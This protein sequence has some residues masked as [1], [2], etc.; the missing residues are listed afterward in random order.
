MG[1]AIDHN[2]LDALLKS[3]GSSWNAG[4]AHGLLCSRLSLAG[5]EGA[6]RWIVQVL[7]DTDADAAERGACEE[8]LDALCAATWQQLVERQSEFNLL[9]P[10]DE[11]PPSVRTEV[12]AQWCE[13]FLHGLVAEKHSEELKKRL[14]EEPL[15][16][17][18]KDMLEITR[19]TVGDDAEDQNIDNDIAELVEY[20]R[21]AV[22]LTYEE[23]AEFRKVE[24][25]GQPESSESLH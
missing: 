3:C 16:D 9:L 17:I 24:D 19:A 5:A 21:V 20:L 25:S 1:Q 12:M 13:G 23:L 6:S 10:D 4:Q 7:A 2:E 11:D 22:Q 18:I 8:E 14:A 15:A